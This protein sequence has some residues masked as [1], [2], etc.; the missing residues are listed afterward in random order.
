MPCGVPLFFGVPS[1][2]QAED[3][4]APSAKSGNGGFPELDS[5]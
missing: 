2:A 5:K 1:A 4:D 3:D